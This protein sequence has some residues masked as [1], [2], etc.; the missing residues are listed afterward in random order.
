MVISESHSSNMVP[1]SL[2]ITNPSPSQYRRSRT[3]ITSC[4]PSH[5]C[6]QKCRVEHSS[7]SH[8]LCL[9]T[10]YPFHPSGFHLPARNLSF[11]YYSFTTRVLVLS[12]TNRTFT[13][14]SHSAYRYVSLQRY[15]RHA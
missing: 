1:S 8:P 5:A 14:A 15:Q 12:S 9:C 4:I 13:N 3:K 7:T 2:T 11:S 6:H 10:H